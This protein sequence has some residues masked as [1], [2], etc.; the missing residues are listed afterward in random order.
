VACQRF[1]AHKQPCR[2]QREH[3]PHTALIVALSNRISRLGAAG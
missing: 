2:G 1:L 3:A